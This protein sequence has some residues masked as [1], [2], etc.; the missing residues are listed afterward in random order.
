MFWQITSDDDDHSMVQALVEG[1][2]T[3]GEEK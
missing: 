3:A 2:L 1:L